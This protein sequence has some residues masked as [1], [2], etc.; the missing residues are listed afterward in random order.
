M[1]VRSKL[2]VLGLVALVVGVIAPNAFANANVRILHGS[3]DVPAVSVYVNGAAAVPTLDPLE[4]TPYLSLPAGT[5]KIAVALAGQ[6]ES[7]AVLRADVAVQDG[8][9]YTGFA[10]GLLSAGTVKLGVQEDIA[11]APFQRSALRVWHNSPDAPNVD[12]IVNG[13]TALSNV[14]YQTVSQYLPLPE[15]SYD[16][17][18]N[19]AGTSTSVFSGK[20]ELERGKAYTAIAQGSVTGKGLGFRVQVLEDATSGAL[21][22]VL[23]ASPNVPAVTVYVN[24]KPVLSKLRTLKASGY[25][26]LDAG[27]YNVAVSLAGKPASAAALKG[28]ITV[29][30]GQ[31]YTA[32]ARGLLGRNLQLAVQKDIATAPAGKSAVRVWHLSPDAPKVDIY[33]NGKKT[34]SKVPYKAASSYLT[35]APGRYTIAVKV[36][37]TKATVWS[38]KVTTKASRAY[39]AT[40]LGAVKAA[41]LK[42]R[43]AL[44]HDA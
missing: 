43:V 2:F 11:R 33:V 13:Q 39:S 23:H 28:K 19:V 26:S 1:R 22:R 32:L 41:G 31:R 35:L 25:L 5:Y 30:D 16:V 34:L 36:A 24:G 10:T 20:V 21:V 37:G 15:G 27:T 8:K 4:A 14:P 12:V 6:P 42:F 40:A 3:P 9:R 17:K 38:G 44:L 18:V 29:V 7:A